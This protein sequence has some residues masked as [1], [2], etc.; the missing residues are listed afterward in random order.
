[1]KTTK[2][3]GSKLE[4]TILAMVK[5]IDPQARRTRGSGCGNEYADISCSFAYIECKKRNTESITIKE[6]TWNHLNYNLPISTSKFTIMVLENKNKKRWVVL[7]CNEF[8]TILKKA[9]KN[10]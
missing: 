1:M 4:E 3:I 8:F 9:S 7:D 5:D 10:G 6:T 2:E